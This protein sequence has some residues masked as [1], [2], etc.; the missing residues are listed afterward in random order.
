MR[1][2]GRLSGCLARVLQK[3]GGSKWRREEMLGT[4]NVSASPRTETAGVPKSDPC[5][6]DRVNPI[7]RECIIMPNCKTY[8][9]HEPPI[10]TKDDADA[11]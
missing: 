7:T 3:L 2:V 6:I 5:V 10:N 11:H 9:H 4:T 8:R 1:V